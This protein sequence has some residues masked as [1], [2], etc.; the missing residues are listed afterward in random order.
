MPARLTRRPGTDFPIL[1]STFAVNIARIVP[2]ACLALLPALSGCNREP[3]EAPAELSTPLP[4]PEAGAVVATVNGVAIHEAW[5]AAL[6]RG[7]G[8]DLSDAAQ[9]TRALDELIE[10]AVLSQAARGDEALSS[11]QT[12]AD[13]ELNALSGRASAI[14]GRLSA[15]REPDE[16]ALKAEYDQQ[17]E[18]NGDKEYQASH[19]LFADEATALGAA[20]AVTGGEDFAAVQARFKERAK[21]AVD[22]GWI[23]LGQLPPEFAA[24]LRQLEP[25]Q[26]TPVP[27]QT[28]YGWHLIHLADT[29]DFT[30]P[31]YEQVREGIRR[32]LLARETRAVIDGLKAQA[33]IEVV[34]APAG[35][36]DSR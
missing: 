9:R 28:A 26:T 27:V 19:L 5:L 20:G 30:P 16:A 24:A 17:R 7:R 8:L 35:A 3:A 22:L 25:G 1:L 11:T 32:M 4:V 14:L 31:P 10:Y 18:V 13:I 29:R 34:D 12:R 2:L 21:Q 6:A 15:E 23:K 36:A 33:R